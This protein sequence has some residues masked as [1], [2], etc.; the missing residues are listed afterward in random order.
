MNENE[1]DNLE[2]NDRYI[3]HLDMDCYYAQVEMKRHNID[4]NVNLYPF[5]LI[6]NR[7]HLQYSNG[8]HQLL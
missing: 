1:N 2:F 7:L 5:C 6:L 8:T 4:Q 3:I